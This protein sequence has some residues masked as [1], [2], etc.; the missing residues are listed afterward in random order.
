MSTK[1]SVYL[2]Y[3]LRHKP[4]V[5]NL[6][7]DGE[8]WCDLKQLLANTDFT[9]AELEDIVAKDAKQ[10]YSFTY[11]TMGGD[12]ELPLTREPTH[13]RA[14]QGHSTT[15]VKLTFKSAVPPV[16][17]YHGSD[18]RVMPTILKEG[19]KAMN[20]HHVHLSADLEVAKSVGGRRK[21][22]FV[23]YEIDVKA[24]LADG[25]KFFISDNGVWLVDAVSAKYLTRTIE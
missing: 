2:S 4:E 19:L 22:G 9:I 15:D 8:G 16:I 14:N 24:M 10:R 7:L 13:I 12:G 18:A 6:Q 5:A 23:V 11:W 3:L 25:I 17:L 20:R 21:R 1:R